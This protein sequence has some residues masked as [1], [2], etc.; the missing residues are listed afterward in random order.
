MEATLLGDLLNV[1][2]LSQRQVAVI[3]FALHRFVADA[4][5]RMNAAA[6]DREGCHFKAGAVETFARDAKDAEAVLSL[7]PQPSKEP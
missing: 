7:F 2:G 3:R 1:H 4:H 6:Q 5:E